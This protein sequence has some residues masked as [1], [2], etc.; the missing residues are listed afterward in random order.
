M[1]SHYLL[2]TRPQAE[3]KAVRDVCRCGHVAFVPVEER[4][5]RVSRRAKRKRIVR[6]PLTPRYVVAR[7]D[8]PYPLVHELD[9]VTGVVSTAGQRQLRG[10]DLD[11]LHRMDGKLAS[12]NVHKALAVGQAVQVRDGAFRDRAA[13]I[14]LIDGA[15][16]TVALEVFERVTRVTMP[17][18]FL[19]PV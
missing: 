14:E 15:S 17:L 19:D 1:S 13:T 8:N 7:V 6:Y 12:T 2:R 3:A 16:A 18:A 11:A 10:A 5:V 4:H 9:H